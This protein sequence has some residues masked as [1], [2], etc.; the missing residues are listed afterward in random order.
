[1]S[2]TGDVFYGEKLQLAREFNQ[3]TQ[4]QLA[5]SVSASNALISQYE[6]GKKHAPSPDLVQALSSVLGFS[7][8][9]FY[10]P[11]TDCVR[12]EECSFRH[13][14]AAPEKLKN[15]V[16]ARA[17]L[18]GMVAHKLREHF[19]FPPL[20]LPQ[21]RAESREEIEAAAEATRQY[22]GLGLDAPLG[23]VGNILENAGVV[24]APQTIDSRKIDAFSRRGDTTVIFLNHS[25]QSA[26]RLIFDIAHE[27]G[28]LVMHNRIPTGSIETENA[29]NYY[30]SAFLMPRAA[31][32]REFGSQHKTLSFKHVFDLKR[33]WRVS[34]ASIIRRAHD[35]G[36]I[37]AVE[38]RRAFQYMSFKK[39]PSQGEPYEPPFHAPS[40][41]INAMSRLGTEDADLTINEL[42]NSLGFSHQVFKDVTGFQV[43]ESIAP[44]KLSVVEMPFG[45]HIDNMRRE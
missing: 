10:S 14:R 3:S 24:I 28:H 2:L 17:T 35:L 15:H 39:W 1:M 16:K 6:A 42:C 11:I 9:F 45:G 22:W 25:G 44:R 23:Q 33:H 4:V 32:S 38:Y 36:L 20:N 27:C 13:L 30:G 43:P 40:L 34:A 5:K 26:S 19:R 12:R 37:G 8:E 7:E 21:R 41:F 29:A 18:F 31:F